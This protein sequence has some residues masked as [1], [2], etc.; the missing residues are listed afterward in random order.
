MRRYGPQD[1]AV[2]TP[3]E[4]DRWIRPF[5]V[6]APDSVE[7]FRAWPQL[8]RALAW[9][10]LYRVEPDLYERLVAGEAIHSAIV[11]WLPEIEDAVELGAGS[12]RFT[13]QLARK[14][15]HVI[16]IEP[17]GP[18][19]ERLEARLRREELLNVDVTEGF[20]DEVPLPDDSADLVAACSAFTVE[21]GHGGQAGL[22]EMERICRPGGMVVIVWPDDPVWLLTRGYGHEVF[23]G[24]A[25]VV[26]DSVDEAARIAR[27]FY[28]ESAPTIEV[29]GRST[30]PYAVLDG[31]GPQA[32]CWKRMS[33]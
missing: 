26:F 16:A 6:D 27:I 3:Q 14:A 12:G 31:R 32:L 25:E 13:V 20:F 4:W 8:R 21:S 11:D 10:L 28:P 24:Q 2:L 19:R 18:L 33:S 17:A 5:G 7:A 15:E 22:A 9:E 23:E 29:A 30:V 1:L